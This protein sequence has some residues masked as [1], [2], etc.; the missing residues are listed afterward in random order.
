MYAHI[1]LTYNDL[2]SQRDQ[3]GWGIFTGSA[4]MKPGGATVLG[5]LYVVRV[6]AHIVVSC[7]MPM[8]CQ[9]QSFDII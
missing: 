2:I 8:A 4:E 7:R 3:T 5:R 9:T 1:L 6:Y